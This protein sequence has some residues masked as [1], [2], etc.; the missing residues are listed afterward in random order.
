MQ[1]KR[2]GAKTELH[3]AIFKEL[4]L[5]DQSYFC[6]TAGCLYYIKL[7][8]IVYTFFIVERVPRIID[9]CLSSVENVVLIYDC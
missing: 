4:Q 7:H 8:K 2:L 5:P 3:K 1:K 6:F 9:E